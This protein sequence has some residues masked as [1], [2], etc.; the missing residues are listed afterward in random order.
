MSPQ[1]W[2][3]QHP[4]VSGTGALGAAGLGAWLAARRWA[5]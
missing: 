5:R 3:S 4:V 1:L 2:A